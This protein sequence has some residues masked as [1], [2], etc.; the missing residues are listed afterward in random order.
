VFAE[1]QDPTL[2]ELDNPRLRS[3]LLPQSFYL[4]RF[5]RIDFGKL[6]IARPIYAKELVELRLQRLSISILSALD[7]ERHEPSGQ[8][9]KS[10]PVQ[11]RA[12]EGEP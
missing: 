7:D 4:F 2:A 9:R 3:R 11:C 1:V 5:E 6:T 12:I 10:V 8:C